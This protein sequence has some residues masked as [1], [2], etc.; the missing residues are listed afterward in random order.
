MIRVDIDG[1]TAR[2]AGVDPEDPPLRWEVSGSGGLW[3]EAEVL[4]DDHGWFQLRSRRGR[5]S[6]PA[7]RRDRLA[8]RPAH[9]LAALP[10]GRPNAPR[11]RRRAVHAPTR[12]LF[13]RGGRRSA[14]WLAWSTPHGCPRSRSARATEPLA[15]RSRCASLRCCHSKAEE[16]LEVREP[17]SDRWVQWTLVESF[18][19]S[20]P[21][22]S[23]LQARRQR[24]R[25]R[26]RSRRP[27]ARRG[28]DAVRRAAASRERICGWAPTATAEGGW[29]TSRPR[30]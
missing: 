23:A 13:D 16:T 9:A 24:R 25:D 4:S 6:V 2:G 18:A 26:A 30:R 3:A 12:D 29:E 1:S 5:A 27:P 22:R 28:L 10:G 8:G 7:R 20:G 21:A 19:E 15:S 17:G 11:R 14:H